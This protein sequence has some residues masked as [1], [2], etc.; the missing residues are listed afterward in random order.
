M[1]IT[2][3]GNVPTVYSWETFHESKDLQEYGGNLTN[4]KT[5]SSMMRNRS[6]LEEKSYYFSD[7]F[8]LFHGSSVFKKIYYGTTV[9]KNHI[10]FYQ[11]KPNYMILALF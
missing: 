9:N 3:L 1:S 2:Y 11:T 4:K 8:T 7:P 6:I 10:Y 5:L